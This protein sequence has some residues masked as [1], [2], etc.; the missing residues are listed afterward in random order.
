MVAALMK[1]VTMREF[2][3]GSSG[4]SFRIAKGVRYRT[5]SFRGH[6]V[7]VG[8]Q[9]QV[10]D[11]GVL[12]VT[13]TRIVF[14]GSRK[15]VEIPYSKL[16]GLEVFTDGIR[17]SASNRQ[18]APLFRLESGDVVGATVNTAVQRLDS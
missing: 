1:E 8:T 5:G 11:T 14:L 18:N 6:S 15:T 10:A 17:F 7:V 12:A 13:S 3:G 4:F 16:V 9:L 2:R